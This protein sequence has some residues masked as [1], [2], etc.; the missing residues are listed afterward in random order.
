MFEAEDYRKLGLNLLNVIEE[1]TSAFKPMG[2]D[3]SSVP[4]YDEMVTNAHAV[5]GGSS[6]D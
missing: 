5:L 4:S 2:I 1:I 3:L 6:K